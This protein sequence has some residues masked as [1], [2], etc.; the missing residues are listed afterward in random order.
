M[1]SLTEEELHRFIKLLNEKKWDEDIKRIIKFL[2]YTG[3][4]SGECFALRWEDID[5]EKRTINICHTLNDI[6]GK[7][8]LTPPKTLCSTRTIYMS[9]TTEAILHEQFEY[10]KQLKKAL[11][12]NYAHPEM[13]FPSAKGD[14][15]NRNSVLTSLK[16]FMR[17]T[18]FEQMTLHILRHCYA[19]MLLNAGVEL[20]AISD[21][22]GHCDINV[23]ADI[24]ADVLWRFKRN[25]ANA[26]EQS[27]S[28]NDS[29]ITL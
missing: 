5:F 14:Y 16:R 2:L 21:H 11:G 12:K 22:L 13:V 29:S 3:V 15:R 19:T 23:T 1:T 7:H 9:D 10:V 17:G 24:Y 18:E 8:S 6:G 26:I 4:R 20:K 27:L 28:L 25:V